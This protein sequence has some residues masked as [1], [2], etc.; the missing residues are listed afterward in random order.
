[1]PNFC[2]IL[3]ENGEE[4]ICIIKFIESSSRI[5][6]ISCEQTLTAQLLL[7][8]QQSLSSVFLEWQMQLLPLFYQRSTNVWPPAAQ[9][10]G[11]K[12]KNASDH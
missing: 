9:Y 12:V 4:W 1:M 10:N 6:Q 11:G 7:T 3:L 5:F 8:H 2:I